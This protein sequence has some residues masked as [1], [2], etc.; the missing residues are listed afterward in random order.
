[1]NLARVVV[2]A[3]GVCTAAH[4]GEFEQIVKA[5]E[6]HYGVSRTHVPL[7]GVAN[8]FLKAKHVEGVSGFKIAMFEDLKG[9][10]GDSNFMDGFSDGG[11]QRIVRV[12][13]HDNEA[14]YIFS[15]EAGKSTRLLIA[16][17][18]S[19]EATV[20]EVKADM[21]ALIRLL[22]DPAHMGQALT[23]DRNE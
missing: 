22:Q 1:V 15:G 7:M 16:T 11:M 3:L 9:S 10:A 23:G 14:T 5:I 2:A 13:D 20:V 21:N 8:L 18:G 6:T 17:F 12:R 4:A 19:N